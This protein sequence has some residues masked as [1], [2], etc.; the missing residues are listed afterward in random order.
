MR[1]TGPGVVAPALLFLACTASTGSPHSGCRSVCEVD[2]ELHLWH[3]EL[4]CKFVS[5]RNHSTSARALLESRD[6]IYKNQAIA[7]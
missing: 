5:L 6:V 2:V 7:M 4:S 1:F 3:F